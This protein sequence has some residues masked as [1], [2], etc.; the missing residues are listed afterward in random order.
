MAGVSTCRIMHASS[1]IRSLT[2]LH[3]GQATIYDRQRQDQE[4]SLRERYWSF[5]G[6]ALHGLTLP[7]FQDQ[8]RRY[9]LS[10]SYPLYGGSIWYEL[11]ELEYICIR[12]V[13]R[14]P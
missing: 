3:N 14:L 10:Y 6:L 4:Q 5:L 1:S 11:S 8:R 9:L 13:L 7:S 2:N 12:I